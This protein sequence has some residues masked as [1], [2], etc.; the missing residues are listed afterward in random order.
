MRPTEGLLRKKMRRA[1]LRDT[2]VALAGRNPRILIEGHWVS[3][4]PR[5]LAARLHGVYEGR[6]DAAAMLWYKL[7]RHG[8]AGD[9][10]CGSRPSITN[11]E[12]RLIVN[13]LYARGLGSAG[14][15]ESAG[16]EWSWVA[17]CFAGL[18]DLLRFVR[19]LDTIAE[20]GIWKCHGCELWFYTPAIKGGDKG[21]RVKESNL[22]HLYCDRC[23]WFSKQSYATKYAVEPEPFA[24]HAERPFLLLPKD[25]RGL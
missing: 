13:G 14:L 12:G 17:F 24:Q 16:P 21:Y 10:G 1:S 23:F 4:G 20:P 19:Y 9:A 7:V 5:N 11:S 2:R 18:V 22:W 25:S 3:K 15:V 8:F 6:V